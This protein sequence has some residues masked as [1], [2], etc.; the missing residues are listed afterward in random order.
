MRSSGFEPPRYCYRQPLKLVRLPVPPRPRRINPKRQGIPLSNSSKCTAARS[1]LFLGR[2]AWRRLRILSRRRCWRLAWRLPWS[3]GGRLT[4]SLRWGLSGRNW[5][6]S[7][8][9]RSSI[10]GRG[11]WLLRLFEDRAGGGGH[12][13]WPALH[14]KRERSHHEDDGAPGGG[15]R[16][17]RGGAARAKGSLASRAAE[18][19]GEIRGVAA[20]EH[21]DDNEHET[22]HDVQRHQ[23]VRH[24]P[25]DPDQRNGNQQRQTPFSPRW[26]FLLPIC[27]PG[28]SR[29]LRL[30][31]S[32]LLRTTA[33]PDSL[34]PRARRQFPP[35]PS[36]PVCCRV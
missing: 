2:R 17:K 16:E 36:I 31:N 11:S 14:G 34:R 26:H 33:G 32:R 19:A 22:N 5:K 8:R 6:L 3:L 29:R 20:L 35:A 18:C 21:D 23:H 28:D 30:K 12:F 7:R 24:A 4:R 1:P 9:A 15:A 13:R 10:R 27:A 25:P